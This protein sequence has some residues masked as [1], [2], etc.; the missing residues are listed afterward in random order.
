MLLSGFISFHQPPLKLNSRF[1]DLHRG[2]CRWIIYRLSI[3][4]YGW[5]SIVIV[6]VVRFLNSEVLGF[7]RNRLRALIPGHLI[8]ALAQSIL[9]LSGPTFPWSVFV[10]SMLLFCP[11][12][13][14]RERH[15]EPFCGMSL[16]EIKPVN[17]FSSSNFI[18]S[19][20]SL[21]FLLFCSAG[22]YRCR[23]SCY[24]VGAYLNL[25][26][27]LVRENAIYLGDLFGPVCPR[28][29]RLHCFLRKRFR[30][31]LWK[32]PHPDTAPCN[33]GPYRL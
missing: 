15:L 18:S 5:S 12:T 26:R 19:S 3:K 9:T 10:S 2:L 4:R 33:P 32:A 11:L 21:T 6:S 20:R 17:C 31:F 16:G 1:E 24:V 13:I 29:K 28:R 14:Y 23:G 30:R 27:V 7:H 8:R 25:H 22:G